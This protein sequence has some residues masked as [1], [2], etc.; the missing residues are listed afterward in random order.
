MEPWVYFVDG[1]ISQW[2]KVVP[3]NACAQEDLQNNFMQVQ[4]NSI[5]IIFVF[6]NFFYPNCLPFSL[7]LFL[8]CARLMWVFVICLLSASLGPL[9]LPCHCSCPFFLLLWPVTD[10]HCQGFGP[11][12]LSFSVVSWAISLFCGLPVRH[13]RNNFWW[14]PPWGIVFLNWSWVIV[15]ST[16][17]ST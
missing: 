8:I 15:A 10:L 5:R 9:S 7:L 16:V 17:L 12:V 3:T 4:S 11:M 6:S 1:K 2:W 14:S 13:S